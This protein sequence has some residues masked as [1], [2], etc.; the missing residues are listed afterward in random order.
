[1]SLCHFT[2][3]VLHQQYRIGCTMR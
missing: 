1:M 3:A 2:P